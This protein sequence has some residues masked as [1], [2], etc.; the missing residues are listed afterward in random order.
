MSATAPQFMFDFGSPNAFL[1]HEAIPAIEQR[2]GVKFEYVPVLLG[3]IFKATNNKSPAETLAGIKNKR[4]FHALETERFL[5]RFHV[6]PYTWNPFF[7]VNTL[8]LMR[9]AIAAQSEGVFEKYVDAAFHHMWVEPKKMDDPEV[10]LKA[11][12]A[13][14]L[15]AAK[16]FSRARRRRRES[17]T[18]REYAIRGRAWRIRLA[19]LLRRQGNVFRQGAVARRRGDG[20]GEMTPPSS[21]LAAGEPVM[22]KRNATVAVIGAGDYIGAEI[23]KKFAAEGFTV[24]AGRRDGA[25]L[26]PLVRKSRPRAD[27]SSARALDARKEDEVAAFLDD[28]DKHAPLEVCIFNVGANVNFPILETTDRVFRKVWEMACWAGFLAGR[29][30]ARLMLPRGKGNIFFTGATASL[31]GGSGF[32]AFASAKFGL[33]AVA[34]S[35]ARELGPKN[36]HVAHLIIDSGVD[37]AWVRQRREQLWGKEALDNPD[38]LMPPASVA[39][40]YWQLYQQ[41]RSAWTFELEIRPFGEKW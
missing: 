6:K 36:I 28:A 14:G 33:R 12:T 25:K 11:L 29:E 10:A 34:Q 13:S 22:E 16:L 8:N 38:L 3:G 27:R 7:P 30:L 21:A 35:M 26:E 19:D 17:Q 39:A 5:K 41:P 15:D 18:D 31:R 9:A 24:F 4:E 1:S 37:T 32:A 23:A 20:F 40:S 2:I